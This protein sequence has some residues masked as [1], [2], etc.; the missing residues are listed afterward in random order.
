MTDATHTPIPWT[1]IPLS[2]NRVF[3]EADASLI[4]LAVN[5][6]QTMLD[7]LR[8][9]EYR[10][11]E[12]SVVNNVPGGQSQE[13]LEKIREAIALGESEFGKD[14][15][16][17]DRAMFQ[18]FEPKLCMPFSVFHEAIEKT[19]GRPVFTH[20]FGL[21]PEAIKAELLG[22]REAPTLAEI[23]ALIPADK[24]VLLVSN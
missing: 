22:E 5:S 14:M 10:I 21:A 20:E 18:M 23:I 24:R 8:A 4:L 7:A 3:T 19:L 9:A 11:L 13:A 1:E 17:R 15:S 2:A 6:H 16:Y 12:V